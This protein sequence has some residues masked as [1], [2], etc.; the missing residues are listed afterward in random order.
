MLLAYRMHGLF[1][2]LPLQSRQARDG[3][4]H[5][6][7]PFLQCSSLREVFNLF[8]VQEGSCII[9]FVVM[10]RASFGSGSLDVF[11]RESRRE[12]RHNRVTQLA[13]A[14][15]K[16]WITDQEAEVLIGE[17]QARI[18]EANN[19]YPRSTYIRPRASETDNEGEHVHTFPIFFPVFKGM[20]TQ[21]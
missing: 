6:L 11:R 7:A 15:S 19:F 3:A 18:R 4:A 1:E 2:A 17:L 10:F 21:T 20:Q 14:A 5:H 13:R 16:G 8:L 9:G 12:P